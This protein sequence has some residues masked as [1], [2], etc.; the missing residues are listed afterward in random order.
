MTASQQLDLLS[1]NS[2]ELDNRHVAIFPV[3][4]GGI[5]SAAGLAEGVVPVS[6]AVKSID[7]S[8][9]K[10]RGLRHRGLSRSSSTF[11]L[12]KDII[13]LDEN[14]LAALVLLVQ[15]STKDEGV[16]S[17]SDVECGGESLP[18]RV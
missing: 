3:L 2:S 5:L 17:S 6:E 9:I 18:A 10:D 11:V 7:K 14:K 12:K 4:A 1:V 15:E 16:L 13:E 8:S